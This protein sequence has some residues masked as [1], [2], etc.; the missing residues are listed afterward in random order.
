MKRTTLAAV[1]IVSVC[2]LAL[3]LLPAAGHPNPARTTTADAF[4]VLPYLQKP[5]QDQMTIT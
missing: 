5:A 1:S 3:P 4:R 2:A